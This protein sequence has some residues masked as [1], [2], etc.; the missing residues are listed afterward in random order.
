MYLFCEHRHMIYTEKLLYGAFNESFA[1]VDE[2]LRSS[3][4]WLCVVSTT[5]HCSLEKYK[6]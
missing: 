2:K 1:C 6:N 3:M 5:F 4:T